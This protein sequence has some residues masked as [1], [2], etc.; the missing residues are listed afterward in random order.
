MSHI[1]NLMFL[2]ELGSDHPRCIW[3]NFINPP[4]VT[5]RFISLLISHN[6][7]ALEFVSD[8][9]I[10]TSNKKIRVW[11]PF[12]GLFE[13]SGMAKVEEVVYSVGIDTNRPVGGRFSGC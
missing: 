3:N 11:K 8:F 9:I 1:I 6:S 13:R 12:L 2:N 4:A 7:L 10:A 5:K